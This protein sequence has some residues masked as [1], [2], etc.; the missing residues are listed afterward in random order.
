TSALADLILPDHTA[1]ESWGDAEPVRGVRTLQ[2]PTVRPLFDTRATVDVLLDAARAMGGNVPAGSFRHPLPAPRRRRGAFRTPP[3]R[4]GEWKEVSASGVSDGAIAS[5][6][7][8]EPAMLAGNAS[9]PVLVVYPSHHLYDG[10]LS[11][12]QA[13]HEI[14]DPVTKTMWGSYAEMHPGT[15]KDLGVELGDMIVVTTEGGEVELPAYPQLA[16]R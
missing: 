4:G 12:V 6:I 5:S 16:V 7:D 10:R 11:R 9:D 1:F 13:L 15:A 14:P 3:G 8:F 2:Q